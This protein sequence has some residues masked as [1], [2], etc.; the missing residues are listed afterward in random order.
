MTAWVVPEARSRIDVNLSDGSSILLRRLGN[1]RG[2]RLYLSHG[3]GFA[4]DGYVPFWGALAGGFDLVMFDFRNHGRNQRSDPARHCY[5]Q[6]VDDLDR[7]IAAGQAEWGDVPATGVFHS[8]SARTAMKHG[9]ERTWRWTALVLF[10]PPNVPPKGHALYPAM[11]EFETR[12]VT[13]ARGRQERFASPDALTESYLRSR[14]SRMWVDGAQALMARS[15]LREEAA[16]DWRLVC[17]PALEAAIYG[18]A[19]TLNLWPMASQY[20]G[21]VKLI[22]ADPAQG[23]ATGPANQALGRENGFDYTPIPGAGHLLQI[24]KPEACLAVLRAFLAAQGIRA[25]VE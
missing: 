25:E 19:T 15:V 21:P 17:A 4:V 13:F 12:L 22:G 10:D 8:M 5:A 9:L 3:N 20:P 11:E 2:P 23:A 14:T 6:M 16:G 1:L 18:E 24:E 7:V